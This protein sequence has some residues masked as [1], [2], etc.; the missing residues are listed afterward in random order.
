MA[1]KRTMTK[2]AAGSLT[3]SEDTS[4]VIEDGRLPKRFVIE[5]RTPYRTTCDCGAE[6]SGTAR[7]QIDIA[8]QI[9]QAVEDAIVGAFNLPAGNYEAQIVLGY[10]GD[11]VS[12]A[13][14]KV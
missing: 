6:V 11:F 14:R 10:R 5:V 7:K 9:R 8:P 4:I 13:M 3:C 2:Q 1:T 12:G